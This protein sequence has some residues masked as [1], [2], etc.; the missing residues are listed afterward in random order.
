MK[1]LADERILDGKVFSLLEALDVKGNRGFC[2][3]QLSHR[4]NRGGV[5]LGSYV[6]ASSVGLFQPYLLADAVLVVNLNSM[7]TRR[8]DV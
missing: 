2:R 8:P 1:V 4:F 5:H 7:T 3:N 6:G